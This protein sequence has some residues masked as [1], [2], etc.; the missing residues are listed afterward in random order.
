MPII[1][2]RQPQQPQMGWT[3]GEHGWTLL[4]TSGGGEFEPFR[5]PENVTGGAQRCPKMTFFDPK[6][7]FLAIF[8]HFWYPHVALSGGLN[9]SNIPP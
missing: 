2:H 6:M 1:G 7:T 4:D 3:L 5:P 9:G 8:G